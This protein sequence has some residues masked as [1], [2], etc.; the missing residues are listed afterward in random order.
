MR[1]SLIDWE[2]DSP[3]SLSQS[4]R[5]SVELG[6]L[7]GGS[8]AARAHT[9]L[10][11]RGRKKTRGQ[12]TGAPRPPRPHP[13][14]DNTHAHMGDA[15]DASQEAK[16]PS[17][18]KT[19]CDMSVYIS[20][21]YSQDIFVHRGHS[22]VA[23]CSLPHLLLIVNNLLL[24]SCCLLLAASHQRTSH[25]HLI[26]RARHASHTR[27]HTRDDTTTHARTRTRDTRHETRAPLPL[28]TECTYTCTRARWTYRVALET[29]EQAH[30]YGAH[31]VVVLTGAGGQVGV[32]VSEL[33][34]S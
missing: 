12:N 5:P 4:R 1:T 22:L 27:T 7:A 20:Y 26:E 17:T 16:T 10:C 11:R 18:A 19:M 30:T 29:G 24:L 34:T 33:L 3:G 15:Q 31:V 6:T 8:V 2:A 23:R 21:D 32:S 14:P 28:P 13:P 9:G 25:S